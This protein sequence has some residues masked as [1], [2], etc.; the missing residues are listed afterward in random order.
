[1][2][3]MKQ[4]HFFR[5]RNVSFNIIV[6]SLQISGGRVNLKRDP[7]DPKDEKM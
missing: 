4:S 7:K 3:K 2:S 5:F 6:V 1:M